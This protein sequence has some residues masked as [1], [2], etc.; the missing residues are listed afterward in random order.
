MDQQQAMAQ[1]QQQGANN[2]LAQ[3]MNNDAFGFDGTNGNFPNMGLNGVGDF[4]QM[5]PM[6]Q[7]GMMNNMMGSF[8]NMM[9]EQLRR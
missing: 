8:P 9:G 6:M 3:G 5:M 4:N 1:S 7:N 2:E